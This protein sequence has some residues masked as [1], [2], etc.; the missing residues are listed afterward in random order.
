[1]AF[2]GPSNY[3]AFIPTSNIWDVNE[4]YSTEVTT[5][6]FKELLVR[7][8][9]NLNNMSLLINI[10]DTGYYVTDEFVNSQCYYP[11]PNLNSSTT[12]NP[13]LRQVYRKIIRMNPTFATLPNTGTIAIPHGLTPNSSWT[14]TRIYATASDTIG[15]NY[16]PI[17]YASPT[18][19]NNIEIRVDATN[20][21]ITTG[22]NRTNF[23]NVDIV[24][25]YLK[26]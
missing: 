20:V 6:A 13:T 19:A 9:Q 24:L 25:E 3:G 1:M 10:K 2:S 14:F 15:F 7:L 11:N 4:I 17:P 22:S 18:L 8:Y 16:I 26:F 23:N 5:P 12:T 21:Y